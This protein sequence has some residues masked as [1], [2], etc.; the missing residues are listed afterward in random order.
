VL[1][2]TSVTANSPFGDSIAEYEKLVFTIKPSLQFLKCAIVFSILL[3]SVTLTMFVA[4]V[5]A[6]SCNALI[7]KALLDFFLKNCNSVWFIISKLSLISCIL[8]KNLSYESPFDPI[9]LLKLR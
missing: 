4:L 7:A 1:L 3:Y 6:I 5:Q 2:D 9:K 8:I